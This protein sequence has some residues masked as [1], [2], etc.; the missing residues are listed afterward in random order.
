MINL[1]SK[2]DLGH[3]FGARQLLLLKNKN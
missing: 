1:K 3:V 2:P